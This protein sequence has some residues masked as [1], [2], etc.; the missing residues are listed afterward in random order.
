VTLYL[1]TSSLLKLYVEE[2]GSLDVVALVES[3]DVVTTL[4]LTYTEARAALARRRREG[5]LSARGL[6]DVRRLLDTEW[7]A[8]FHVD[9]TSELCAQATDLAERHALRAYDSLHLAAFAHVT[10][11]AGVGQTVFSSADRELNR[12]AKSLA[13]RCDRPAGQPA[14]SRKRP[15]PAGH[16]SCG[17]R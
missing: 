14:L 10:R 16:V 13:R 6:D 2:Q 4:T 3:A 7:T 17:C 5:T 12:A 11:Q 15:P 9:V 8:F 1:D